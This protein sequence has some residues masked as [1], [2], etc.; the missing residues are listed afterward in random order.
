MFRVA[1]PLA[2]LV[3]TGLAARLTSQETTPAPGSAS[4]SA[5]AEVEHAV[6]GAALELVVDEEIEEEFELQVE[7]PG[8]ESRSADARNWEHKV[9]FT[10][11]AAA[12]EREEEVTPPAA[13]VDQDRAI[14]VYALRHVPAPAAADVIDRLFQDA[15]PSVLAHGEERTN[16]LVVRATAKHHEQISEFLRALDKPR[17]GEDVSPLNRLFGYSESAPAK[18]AP[19][20]NDSPASASAGRRP[21]DDRAPGRRAERRAE[22]LIHPSPGGAP[23]VH[24]LPPGHPGPPGHPREDVLIMKRPKVVARLLL[25]DDSDEHELAVLA[26]RIR[27]LRAA[28]PPDE[29]AIA[30]LDAQLRERIGAAF[31]ARQTAQRAE[32]AVLEQQLA[33]IKEAI[34]KRDQEKEQWIQQR[35]EHW[36]SGKPKP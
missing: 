36:L 27:N 15:A 24:P 30:E 29:E 1:I 34:A 20:T 31:D 23:T 8:A 17:F 11:E 14:R 7:A 32:V 5:S 28:S 26:E 33:S 12:D 3:G 13:G 21:S 2:L 4:A 16:Q 9:E 25:T 19:Q 6:N 18:E 35:L 10:L 22:I